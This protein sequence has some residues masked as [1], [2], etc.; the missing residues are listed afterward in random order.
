MFR[1]DR[2][3]GASFMYASAR[4]LPTSVDWRQKG[5]VTDVKDQGQCGMYR[6]MFKLACSR[7]RMSDRRAY[8]C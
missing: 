2:Q 1:G 6:Y 3:G 5:A 8:R 7:N 4:D